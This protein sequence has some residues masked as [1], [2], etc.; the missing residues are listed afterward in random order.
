WDTS[1]KDDNRNVCHGDVRCVDVA[2]SYIHAHSRLVAAV[3]LDNAVIVETADA[4][5]VAARD[6]VQ[7]VKSIVQLLEGA[8]RSESVS[9][10][11]VYRPWGTYQSLATGPVFQVKHICVNPGA[12]LSLQLHHHRSVHCIASR[13]T[14]TD[15]LT[16]DPHSSLYQA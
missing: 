4:V 3:G 15:T 5:L 12:S 13:R 10:V 8:G 1:K 7:D 14:T 6:K 2:E 16:Y 11:L 9:H